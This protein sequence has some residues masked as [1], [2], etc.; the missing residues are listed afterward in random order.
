[1][2]YLLHSIAMAFGFLGLVLVLILLHGVMHADKRTERLINWAFND[3]N[4][5]AQAYIS[6]M[7][8]TQNP[9]E[10]RT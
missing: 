3:P 2:S 7:R 9:P 10:Y 4:H 6:E 8:G 1:M 5:C